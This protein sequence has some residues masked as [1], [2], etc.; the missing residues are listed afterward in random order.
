M[1]KRKR[2][3][4]I[5]A[6]NE[7]WIG[8][9]YYIENLIAALGQL[10]DVQQPKLLIFTSEAADAERLQQRVQ[11]PHWSFRRFERKL[12][13]PERAMNK[14]TALTLKRRFI[15]SLYG[16]ID[17]V[18]PLPLGWRHY[19]SRVPHHLYWIPDFQ[20]HYLPAFFKPE[21]I[22]ERKA[23]Q[24]LIIQLARH[25]IFSSHAAQND[26]NSIYPE[27][28]LAQY[29]LQF[30][31]TS[32]LSFEQMPTTLARYDITQPYFICSNQFWKHKNHSVV[33]R[34]LAHFR[35]VHPQALV[36]FT[37]KEYDHRNP[38]YF[39]ELKSLRD[40]LNLQREVRFL[41]FIPREDQL[42]LMQSAVA[43]IQP[44]LFEGWSTVVEDAKSLNAQVIA[45][46]LN[47]HEEQLYNYGPKLFFK[48]NSDD[49][50]AH[51]MGQALTES[52]SKQAYDYQH[53]VL[54][55]A[56]KFVQIVQDILKR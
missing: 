54:Q 6:Y 43:V 28:K 35:L 12:S 36:L 19:F 46:N 37:G 15:S 52:L 3:A 38:T 33:L 30:A 24:Q 45:S 14:L 11:Y 31:V 16:D 44:S 39:D 1:A 8:G 20:E 41:G 29:V 10:P 47:V 27:N 9:T 4:L 51:C 48:C 23:D 34:A 40:E 42:S 32:S 17:L 50:L 13:L 18:F 55:F 53:D 22:Q 21:E 26:F 56:L 49:E 5:Y 7:N 2:V 25:I